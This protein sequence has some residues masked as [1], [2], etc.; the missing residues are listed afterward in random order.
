MELNERASGASKEGLIRREVEAARHEASLG[1]VRI[2]SPF[3]AL[4]LAVFGSALIFALLLWLF[5]GHYTRRVHVTGSLA[6]TNGIAP[7]AAVSPGTVTQ[8]MVKDGDK[9]VDGAP[10]L[11]ITQEARAA[12]L[13]D[14]RKSISASL[15][16][17]QRS[18][19]EDISTNDRL[20]KEQTRSLNEARRSL[21]LQI[22]QIDV[23]MGIWKSSG[24]R[25]EAILDRIHTQ[26]AKGVVSDVQLQ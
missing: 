2:A 26:I 20:E 19:E 23:Q 9:V 7:I 8:V 13:G 22:E 10:L 18:L 15:R 17:S 21:E 1:S 11:L 5:F 14:T 6:T 25:Q 3:S 24:S 4:A 12:S 16:D